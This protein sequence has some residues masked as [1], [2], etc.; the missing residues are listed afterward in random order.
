[1]LQEMQVNSSSNNSSITA[2][3]VCFLPVGLWVQL[4][5]QC[6]STWWVQGSSALHKHAQGLGL[7]LQVCLQGGFYTSKDSLL[8]QMLLRLPT[9][10]RYIIKDTCLLVTVIVT[11]IFA[12]IYSQRGLHSPHLSEPHP[13]QG[14]GATSPHPPPPGSLS[15]VAHLLLFLSGSPDIGIGKTVAVTAAGGGSSGSSGAGR[16][17]GGAA[18]GAAGRA[19]GPGGGDISRQVSHGLRKP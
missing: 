17:G 15:G 8:L 14:P 9:A 18:G 12:V 5:R 11:V 13:Q 2:G 1:M 16:G 4:C 10:P 7:A 3:M 19:V 6:W